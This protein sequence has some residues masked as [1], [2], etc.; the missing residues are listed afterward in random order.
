MAEKGKLHAVLA[1][2]DDRKKTMAKIL[3]ET[4]KT[5]TSRQTH[6]MGSS[7]TYQAFDDKDKDIPRSEIK[8]VVTTVGEKVD[9]FEDRASNFIDV[10]HQKE[11]ANCE[12]K[13]TITIE[14]DGES[15]IVVAENVPVQELV[16]LENLFV[17]FRSQVYNNI[18]TLDPNKKWDE[19]ENNPGHYRTEAYNTVRTRNQPRVIQLAPATKEHKEQ[20]QIVNEDIPVGEYTMV[21][22]STCISP[23]DK[24]DKLEKID[25]LIEAIKKA[26]SKA[27]Q[28]EAP[29]EKIAHKLFKFIN[30]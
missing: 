28:T 23:K 17:Q 5:L 10:V 3:G 22:F 25:E 4:M 26:R 27:N 24:A 16:Q 2:Y 13:G 7:K 14:R 9:Y 30:S 19:D 15:P 6:F 20:A 18:P 11:V 1:V 21:D 29:N 8:H 12:A